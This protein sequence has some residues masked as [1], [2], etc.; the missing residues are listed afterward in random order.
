MDRCCHVRGELRLEPAAALLRDAELLAEE[1]LCSRRAEADEHL[2]LDRGQLGLEPRTTGHLLR[3][4]RLRVDAP[5]AARLPL[6]VL[7]GVRHVGRRPVYPRQLE[8]LVEDAPGGADEGSARLV[9]LIPRLLADEEN[10]RFRR[11]L[12]EDGLRPRLPQGAAA[13]LCR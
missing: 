6:E 11:S 4:G 7:D 12:A 9:L 5:L 10:P 3:P 13:A 1:R 2:R 8:S